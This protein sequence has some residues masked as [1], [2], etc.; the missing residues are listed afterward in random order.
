MPKYQIIGA[1][2][3]SKHLG[4]IEAPDAEAAKELAQKCLDIGVSLCH[5]C[6]RGMSDLEVEDIV[7]E[8]TD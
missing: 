7:E 1:I 5:E 6:S 2:I 3:G 8:D 4:T